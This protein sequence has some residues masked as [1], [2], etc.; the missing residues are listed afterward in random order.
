MLMTGVYSSLGIVFGSLFVYLTLFSQYSP[1]S[2]QPILVTE[3]IDLSTATAKVT[4][5]SPAPLDGLLIGISDSVDALEN[6]KR[7]IE[8]DMAYDADIVSIA[9]SSKAFLGRA[10]VSLSIEGDILPTSVA[11]SVESEDEL[12]IYDANYPFSYESFSVADIHI[13]RNPPIPLAVQFTIPSGQ[14][15]NI[16]VSVRYTDPPTPVRIEGRPVTVDKYLVVEQRFD[17]Q[18]LLS[19]GVTSSRVS[20]ADSKSER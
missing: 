18:P 20:F 6:G 3:R 2:P 1:D 12:V 14:R 8:R 19:S 15:G 4:V 17:L 7:N 10:R 11:L 9:A 13:G 5:E 16:A